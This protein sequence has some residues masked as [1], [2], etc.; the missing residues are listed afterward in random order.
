LSSAFEDVTNGVLTFPLP[1]WY[2]VEGGESELPTRPEVNRLLAKGVE[3]AKAGQRAEAYNLF[4]DVIELDRHNEVAWLWL[5]TVTDDLKDQRV[6][7]E[8]VLIIN[9]DNTAARERLAALYANGVHQANATPK[10]EICPQ[11]GAGNRDFVRECGACGYAFVRPCVI[12]G[13]FNPNDAQ[14]CCQCGS[15][16]ILPDARVAQ[17]S[18]QPPAAMA[19]IPATL[20]PSAITLWPVVAFWVGV[21]VFFIAGGIAALYQFSSIVLYARGVVQNLSPN[22]IAW[23]PVGLFFLVFGLVGISL[24]WQL[25]HRRS[26]GYYGSLVFGLV[27]TLLGPAVSLVLEPPNYLTTVCTGLMPAAA[28]MFTLAAM[29]GFE[30]NADRL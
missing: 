17:P 27:L 21:S 10:V 20:R 30:S 16:L 6:C 19:I 28:V 25:A 12:C 7:L 13:E 18:Q 24:A 2:S 15:T 5:S 8:N 4:L 23:L 29:A 11:C 26:G 22:E 14:T 1:W 9:P 3:S